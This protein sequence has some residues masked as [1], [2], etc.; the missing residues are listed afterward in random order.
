MELKRV[1]RILFN[2]I[3]VLFVSITMA[4]TLQAAPPPPD[5]SEVTPDPWPRIATV[6]GDKY[7]IYQPQMDSW[8]GYLLQAKSAVSVQPAGA[9]EPVFGVLQFTA[10]T[11]VDRIGRIVH[12]DG[13]TIQK[14]TMPSDPGDAARYQAGFAA[15]APPSGHA[16]SLDRLEAMLAI[17]GAEKLSRKTPVK[18]DPPQFVFSQ[19]PALLI[20]VDGA[21]AWRQVPGTTLERAINTRALLLLDDATGSFYLHLFD[22]YVTAKSLEGSWTVAKKVPAAVTKIA[23]QLAQQGVVDL[24]E[25]QPDATTSKKPSLKKGAPRVVV[26]TA[27]TELIVTAGEPQWLPIEQTMLLYVKN[28]SG[29]IFKNLND[30][31]TYVLVTGRWFRAPDFAGPWQYVDGKG[32]PP[33]FARIPNDSPKENVKASVPGTAQA[34]EAVIAASIPQTATVDRSK[35]SFTPVYNGTPELKP[36]ADTP[37]MYAVNSPDPVIMVEGF[38][39]Y[40]VRNGIWFTAS[41]AQGPWV[42]ATSIPAVIYSIPASSPLHYVTYVKIYEVTPTYVVV[43][44]TPGYMG[45]VVTSS[46]VVVYGTGY[47]YPPYVVSTVWYPAPVTY[48]YAANVTYTPW[49]GWAVGFGLGWAMGVSYACAPAP[50][51]G[52]MPYAPYHGAAYVPGAG[53][54]AWG[55]G[56]WAATTGNVYKSSG[57]TSAVTRTSGGYNAW[58]G[59]SWSNKV[60]TSYNSTTGR[61]SAGQ[62]A[63]VANAYSGNYASGQRGATYNPTTGVAA[64]GGTVTYGNA[65]TGAQNTVSGAKVSGPGGQTTAAVKSGDNYYAG[66]DG[67]AY[68]YNSQTGTAQK[69]ENGSWNTVEKP[70]ESLGAK[71]TTPQSLQSQEAARQKGDSRSAASSWGSRS[72]GDSFGRSEGGFGADR[73]QERSSGG[74]RGGRSWG[75]GGW[76]GGDRGFEGG[77]R[78]FGGGG[79]GGGRRR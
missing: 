54:A 18:N 15:M 79:F 12:L 23:K 26:A 29:N 2:A 24:M 43:G 42:A 76:G 8:D 48:G 55:P 20:P 61:I 38:Q 71:A 31:Q 47:T 77:G 9:P 16:M 44:Y 34:E 64:R 72:W 65:Y 13:F 14:L 37:L 49:T 41:S 50:Y 36:I 70:S 27:P 75:G 22:G 4:A 35:A 52:A 30:Q 63:S 1:K 53:A 28:S 10:K 32:L 56:G 17:E 69:Y 67:N 59:N 62:Q 6:G 46:G 68:K 39:W 19:T 21:P 66:H 74:E 3:F 40:A 51:W 7:T 33:D 60:G 58:T 25:G 45:T 57:A 11:Q 73:T 5:P 78:S